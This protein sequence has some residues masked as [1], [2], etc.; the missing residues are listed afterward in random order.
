MVRRLLPRSNHFCK[1]IVKN[2]QISRHREFCPSQVLRI[3]TG[4]FLMRVKSQYAVLKP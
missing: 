1:H 3:A 4:L 2:S